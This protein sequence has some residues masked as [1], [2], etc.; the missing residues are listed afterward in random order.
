MLQKDKPE[1]LV[2]SPPC[3]YFSN[4]QHLNRNRKE[5][6]REERH[7][8]IAMVDFAVEM[9]VFQHRAGRKF[10]FEHPSTS[11]AWSLP[12]LMKLAMLDGMYAVDFD[13]CMFGQTV[14]GPGGERGLAKKRTR[15]YTNSSVIDRL[16]DKQCS[17]EHEHKA[18]LGGLATQ[19]SAYPSPMCDAFIDG[20]LIETG[21][22]MSMLCNFEHNKSFGMG[23]SESAK[24]NARNL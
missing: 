11:R 12:S 5:W 20:I 21:Q 13:Q 24:R 4:F 17:G 7:T 8:A 15:L 3:T 1:L 23:Q 19:A 10:V 18:L 9:C 14:V 22:A 16:M 2:V 6:Q